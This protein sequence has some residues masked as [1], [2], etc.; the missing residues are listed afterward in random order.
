MPAS[1]MAHQKDSYKRSGRLRAFYFLKPN[2]MSVYGLKRF[3][4][5]TGFAI[6]CRH[7]ESNCVFHT[8]PGPEGNRIFHLYCGLASLDTHFNIDR[9]QR[10]AR[11]F[12]QD[13]YMGTLLVWKAPTHCIAYSFPRRNESTSARKQFFKLSTTVPTYQPSPHSWKTFHGNV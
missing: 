10:K 9:Q 2:L 7:S 5:P 13:Q 3:H 8:H 11:N 1:Q 6:G 4:T 12:Y